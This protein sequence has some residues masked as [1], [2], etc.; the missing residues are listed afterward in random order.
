MFEKIKAFFSRKKKEETP[1]EVQVTPAEE[2][3]MTFVPDDPLPEPPT[4]RYTPEYAEILE[5]LEK[6]KQEGTLWTV[7]PAET[8]TAD[9]SEETPEMKKEET[10]SQTAE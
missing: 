2:V 9:V 3:T 5:K 1:P 8:E 10:D 4:S 7:K 6:E